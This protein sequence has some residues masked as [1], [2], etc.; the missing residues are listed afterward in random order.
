MSKSLRIVNGDL[1]VGA[2]RG[3]EQVDR[4]DKL[5]QDLRLWVLE[6][7]GIDPATPTYGNRLDGGIIDD[8]EVE[9]FIGQVN[10]EDRALEVR[11][12]VL[13][14]LG[15]YQNMQLDKIKTEAMKFAGKHT[16]DADEVLHIVNSVSVSRQADQIIVRVSCQTLSGKSFDLIIPAQG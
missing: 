15:R 16:L 6:R 12:E 3:F 7:I 8:Q 13:D 14:L 11:S 1:S 2:G 9:S 4:V 5:A 10:S